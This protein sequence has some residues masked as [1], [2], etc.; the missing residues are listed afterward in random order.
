MNLV[1]IGRFVAAGLSMSTFI[2]LFLHDSW[3]AENLFL[4]PDLILCAALAAGALLPNQ[5][6]SR[7]LPIAFGYT[8]GV[9]T[10]S[11][12]SYAVRGEVGLPSLLGA[13][14]A[15]ALAA[16][17]SQTRRAKGTPQAAGNPT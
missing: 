1:A 17:I 10:C 4:V 2:F 3:R 14:L 8:A 12:A 6:A 5:W 11:V 13:F 15:A 16:L 9:L 7:W